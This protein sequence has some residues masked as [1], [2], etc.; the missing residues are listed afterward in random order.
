[1]TNTC[2]YNSINYRLV[3]LMLC[4][5]VLFS[6]YFSFKN[7][8][9][10][11]ADG[12]ALAITSGVFAAESGAGAALTATLSVAAPYALVIVAA[13]LAA[14]CIYKNR[15]EIGAFVSG[16]MHYLEGIGEGVGVGLRKAKD[17]AIYI[18]S[19]AKSSLISYMDSIKK[20]VLEAKSFCRN[21]VVPAGQTIW[22][23]FKVL[24]SENMN[25]VV[26]SIRSINGF[27]LGTEIVFKTSDGIILKGD[28]S[29]GRTTSIYYNS[30]MG[31]F[32]GFSYSGYLPNSYRGQSVSVG[33]KNYV[34]FDESI[35]VDHLLNYG[36]GS[37]CPSTSNTYGVD[38]P[39]A[40]SVDATKVISQSTGVSTWNDVVGK[41][42]SDVIGNTDAIG[43][44]SEKEMEGDIA[45]SGTITDD[46]AV[47]LDEA[48]ANEIVN[49][50][51]SSWDN[52]FKKSLKS[53][54]EMDTSQGAPPKIY[55]NLHK[56]FG[57]AISQFDIPNPFP[58]KETVL[59]DFE[60]INNYKFNGVPLIGFF[61][62]IVGF[63]F[64]YM[65]L[66]YCLRKFTPDS[67]I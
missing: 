3:S 48:I 34:S 50:I 38:T 19:S 52:P 6:S 32:S 33:F 14:G 20:G 53:I 56:L 60:M 29:E 58:D 49:E 2:K 25:F 43:N 59:I 42:Y 9:E 17:G 61:R 54:E 36:A 11:Y 40:N 67:V 63:G 7:E 10:A 8:V 39:F 22:T 16:A 31:R 44:V 57:A 4:F 23:D 45:D 46:I 12:L 18:T 64:I 66:L 47:S 55:F 41:T 24:L 13:G 1:M 30:S 35:S 5:T 27:P 65:T 37:I 15:V 28:I 21:V 62:G 51:D 26:Q